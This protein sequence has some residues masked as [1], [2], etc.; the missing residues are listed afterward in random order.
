MKKILTRKITLAAMAFAAGMMIT[1]QAAAEMHFEAAVITPSISVRVGNTPD[2][3][4]MIRQVNPL[5]ARRTAY[6]TVRGDLEIARRLAWYTGVPVGQL[7]QH[8]R[9]DYSW[10]EIGEWLYVPGNVVRAAMDQQN[11]NRFLHRE[12]YMAE[13]KN[14]HE[15]GYSKANYHANG[16]SIGRK[17]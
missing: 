16:K 7:L 12:G 14:G 1:A 6:R 15:R 11:W 10:F 17:R 8:R 5:P 2:G 4:P 3:Y 9:Y 13:Y